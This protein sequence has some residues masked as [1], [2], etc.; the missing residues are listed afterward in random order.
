LGK[1]TDSLNLLFR[2]SLKR[3][4]AKETGTEEAKKD[5]MK[6]VKNKMK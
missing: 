1:Y 2:Q 3:K 5:E 4:K 6:R